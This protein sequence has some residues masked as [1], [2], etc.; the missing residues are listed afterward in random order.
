M[1]PDDRSQE[2][3]FTFRPDRVRGAVILTIA[4]CV[5]GSVAIVP[6]FL[7]VVTQYS[8]PHTQAKGSCVV[9]GAL[10]LLSRNAVYLTTSQNRLI[11]P[12]AI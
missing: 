4:W 5:N 10:K 12:G 7:T 11:R 2:F 6:A 8:V 9:A 3:R 1:Y